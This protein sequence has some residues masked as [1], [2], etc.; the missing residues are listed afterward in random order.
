MT[1]AFPLGCRTAM[2]GGE[3]SRSLAASGCPGEFSCTVIRRARLGAGG[4]GQLGVCVPDPAGVPL[5]EL[6][7]P[8]DSSPEAM[9]WLPAWGPACTSAGIP[10]GTKWP[11]PLAFVAS[12]SIAVGVCAPLMGVC[13][14]DVKLAVLQQ[15]GGSIQRSTVEESAVHFQ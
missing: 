1:G 4:A 2:D 3:G 12:S 5:L 11:P 9:K 14:P 8:G 6:M 10:E 7:M 15:N 13:L